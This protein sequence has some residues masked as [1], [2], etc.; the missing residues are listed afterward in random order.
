MK[1]KI[2]SF[3]QGCHGV[4]KTVLCYSH[5]L[6]A[7]RSITV[8]TRT[9]APRIDFV[10]F[11]DGNYT[12]YAY[13]FKSRNW[14]TS[15][16]T[17]VSFASIFLTCIYFLSIK[18]TESQT[19]KI[20][21]TFYIVWKTEENAAKLRSLILNDLYESCQVYRKTCHCNSILLRRRNPDRWIAE[22]ET[23][24]WRSVTRWSP[25]MVR[26][27]RRLAISK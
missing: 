23:W 11:V 21:S 15:S 17:I 24:I 26:S 27:V 13:L 2:F 3:G 4:T 16:V 8:I 12:V 25:G 5:C 10:P 18:N 9:C 20:Y 1:G 22:I 14:A 7:L 6:H 19:K